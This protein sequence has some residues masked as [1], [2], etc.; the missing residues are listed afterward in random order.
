MKRKWKKKAALAALAL[1]L[2]LAGML[3]ADMVYALRE[4]TAEVR[5]AS[6]EGTAAVFSAS[7]LAAPSAVRHKMK[8]VLDRKSGASLR[9]T[10]E[11]LSLAC[12]DSNPALFERIRYFFTGDSNSKILVRTDPG[13]RV[14][15]EV[16]RLEGIRRME[17]VRG[18]KTLSVDLSAARDTVTLRIPGDADEVR[19]FSDEDTDETE[20]R[21]REG[22][23]GEAEDQREGEAEDQPKSPADYG[24]YDEFASAA[25]GTALYRTPYTVSFYNTFAEGCGDEETIASLIPTQQITEENCTEVFGLNPALAV[26]E[27]PLYLAEDGSYYAVSL[28]PAAREKEMLD[29]QAANLFYTDLGE[30]YT[31]IEYLGG[32]VF[33]IPAE[34]VEGC[35][36]ERL[37][38]AEDGETFVLGLRIQTLYTCSREEEG[39]IRT[40]PA[41]ISYPDG[42]VLER[43]ATADLDTGA[44]EVR[45]FAEDS[46]FMLTPE[47]YEIRI[48]VNGGENGPAGAEYR[49]GCLLFAVGDPHSVCSLSIVITAKPQMFNVPQRFLAAKARNVLD[50]GS[51]YDNKAILVD[52]SK[53]S[54]NLAIGDK[55]YWKDASA[56]IRLAGWEDA[57]DAAGGFHRG[58]GGLA[59][60]AAQGFSFY[61]GG[62]E[63]AAVSWFINSLNTT[64][65]AESVPSWVPMSDEYVQARINMNYPSTSIGNQ[66]RFGYITVNP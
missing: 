38:G 50:F 60:R 66:R 1:V 3:P 23:E 33:R 41:V 13:K 47:D 35:F 52:G 51:V 36:K 21:P 6:R 5:S 25:A 49:D 61:N 2:I 64:A 12:L 37:T 54:D 9:I 62:N 8:V 4:G 24:S 22:G 45:I 28:V 16:D 58:I 15:M 34:R 17:I 42:I 29:F 53:M 44:A 59:T 10:Q 27:S 65:A 63:N 56:A 31:D 55:F 11:D 18:A 26:E 19:V 40:I 43:L 14:L 32:G 57:T 30:K 7:S 48:S 20:V 46:D 39:D